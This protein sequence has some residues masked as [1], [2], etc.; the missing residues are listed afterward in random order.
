MM[1]DGGYLIARTRPTTAEPAEFTVTR[2]A[3]SGDTLFRRR[4]RYTPARYTSALLDTMAW[5]AVRTPGPTIFTPAGEARAPADLDVDV[6]WR[7]IRDAMDWPEFQIPVE[8][9]PVGHDGTLWLRREDDGGPD[10]RYMVLDAE[11]QARGI[12]SLPRGLAIRWIS[13]DRFWAVDTDV[14]GVPWLVRFRYD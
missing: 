6:A 11:G 14:L 1:G 8:Q 4:F 13:A 9:A 3:E 5:R 2:V 10:Y 12:L 7:E